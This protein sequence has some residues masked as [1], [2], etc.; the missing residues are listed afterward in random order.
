MNHSPS[1]YFEAQFWDLEESPL[2]ELEDVLKKNFP[3]LGEARVVVSSRTRTVECRVLLVLSKPR[4]MR[5][6]DLA[7]VIDGIHRVEPW[8]IDAVETLVGNNERYDDGVEGLVVVK[9]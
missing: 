9:P 1:K 5:Y 7:I 2:P 4:R 6:C 8:S 3:T